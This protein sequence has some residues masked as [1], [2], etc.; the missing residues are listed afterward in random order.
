MSRL[1]ASA[2]TEI[3]RRYPDAPLIG[4]AGVV[5]KNDEVLLIRR[6]RPP[7]LGRWSIPGGLVEVGENLTQ[8]LV[9]ELEEET[10][11]RVQ[12]AGLIE[13]VERID[14][15]QAGRA[16]YHYVILDY[17]CFWR[18][19]QPS[20]ASDAERAEWFA[21]PALD[22]LGLDSTTQ[23]VIEKARRMAGGR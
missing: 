7:A 6:G 13:V 4:V 19:G 21:P 2:V 1:D 20:P 9:R 14:R 23:R 15:D 16:R 3:N 12:V 10:R 8:A 5:F 11:V 22:R 17:L 18:S